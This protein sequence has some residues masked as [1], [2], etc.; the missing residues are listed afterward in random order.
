MKQYLVSLFLL[1]SVT[2][3][4]Q[5]VF[6]YDGISGTVDGVYYYQPK[7]TIVHSKYDTTVIYKGGDCKVHSWANEQVQVSSLSCLVYHGAAGCPDG[8]LNQKSI[9]TNCLRHIQVKETRE[10]QVVKDLYEEALERLNKLK[11]Q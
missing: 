3:S 9:C 6:N 11:T 10:I 5:S 8:W 4:S 2:A 7:N 1:I